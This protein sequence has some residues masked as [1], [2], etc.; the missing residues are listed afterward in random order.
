MADQRYGSP[1]T[2]T[3]AHSW[4]QMFPD[5]LTAFKTYC[6][7]YDGG[8]L[9]DPAEHRLAAG[10]DE[11]LA[12]PKGVLWDEVKRFENPHNYYVDLSQKLWDIKQGLL[13]SHE[14]K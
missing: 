2:G 6:Q 14:V 8:Q 3:M 13:N 5:E 7:L 4:V 12:H 10:G 11:P 9:I 1:A